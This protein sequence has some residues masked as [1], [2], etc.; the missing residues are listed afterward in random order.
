MPEMETT[1]FVGHL[2]PAASKLLRI[3]V[4]KY[5]NMKNDG[6]LVNYVERARQFNLKL[7]DMY[8]NNIPVGNWATGMNPDQFHLVLVDFPWCVLREEHDKVPGRTPAERKMSV[9]NTLDMA[10]QF[11]APGGISH[12]G[13]DFKH[14]IFFK[15]FF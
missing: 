15:Q 14:F 13:M 8:M 4:F 12:P 5:A 9:F 6:E 7:L 3:D 2:T 1:T 11:V 10:S